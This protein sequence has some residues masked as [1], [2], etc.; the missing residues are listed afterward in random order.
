MVSSLRNS[1]TT[2]MSKTHKETKVLERLLFVDPD[3]GFKKTMQ[4]NLSKDFVID[5]AASLEDAENKLASGTQYGFVS[6]ELFLPSKTYDYTEFP[7]DEKGENG[8]K[9]ISLA[10]RG[11]LYVVVLTNHPAIARE[12]GAFKVYDK[13]TIFMPEIMADYINSLHKKIK[14]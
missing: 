14:I 11:G 5:M 7:I 9:V 2:R 13:H 6:T 8:H 4:D 12:T 3:S 10:R 1:L